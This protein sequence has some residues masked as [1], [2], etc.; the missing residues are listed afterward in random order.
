MKALWDQNLCICGLKTE[1]PVAE[2]KTYLLAY[3]GWGKIYLYLY[4][5]LVKNRQLCDYER[6]MFLWLWVYVCDFWFL[7]YV[8]LE[9]K[10]FYS[11]F[12][13]CSCLEA[14]E[15]LNKTNVFWLYFCLLC[16]DCLKQFLFV[17]ITEKKSIY[18]GTNIKVL[19]YFY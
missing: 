7:L 18:V 19:I 11:M 2:I 17:E 9:I 14:I 5:C 6:L 12:F 1:T 15:I 13:F 4:I 3:D 10:E 8:V 16:A